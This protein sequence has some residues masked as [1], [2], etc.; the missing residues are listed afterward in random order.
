MP[1]DSRDG[2]SGAARPS[3]RALATIRFACVVAIGIGVLSLLGW[4]AGLPALVHFGA[5]AYPHWPN[6]ALAQSGLAL[7]L[8]FWTAGHRAWGVPPLALAL[9]VGGGTFLQYATSR[10]LGIDRL[11]LNPMLIPT[12][13]IIPGRPGILTTLSL[14]LLATGVL[15][16]L[17]QPRWARAGVLAL[18]CLALGL[19]VTSLSLL[20]ALPKVGEPVV[21]LA[22]SIPS[23]LATAS[24]GLAL[25]LSQPGPRD[26]A[27]PL[28]S[29]W[30]RGSPWTRA[31][32]ALPALVVLPAILFPIEV[33]LAQTGRIRPMEIELLGSVINLAL[34]VGLFA[35]A[36]VVLEQERRTL[37]ESEARLGVATEAYGI[38]VF[39]WHMWTGDLVWSAGAE[40]KLG[41][42]PGA[43]SSYA[44]WRAHLDPAEAEALLA[45][46]EGFIARG[47]LGDRF[48]YQYRF[49]RPDGSLRL[50]ENSA[51]VLCDAQG[52]PAR[53]IGLAVDITDRERQQAQLRSLIQ[54]VPSAMIV[55]DAQGV[56]RRFN[57]AAEILFGL[58]KKVVL[59]RDVA[60]L[61][62]EPGPGESLFG[63]PLVR[64]DL[65]VPSRSL[66]RVV[67]RRA[68][69][70]V[71]VELSVGEAMAAGER[72]FTIFIRDVSE[73]EA[74]L[75]RLETLR[76]EY[77][78]ASRLTTMGEMAAGLA[79]ELN[80]PLAAC[81]NFL[82]SA[83]LM[84]DPQAGSAVQAVR[85]AR[86]QVLRAGAITRKL[87]DFL[88]KG[89]AEMS[90]HP[91]RGVIEDALTLALAGRDRARL[92]IALA[93]APEADSMLA[94]RVQIQ[95][96][97]VNLIRNA[98][99][100]IA[101]CADGRGTLFISTALAE[102]RMIRFTI[103]DTGP[104]I[105]PDILAAPFSPFV[106][107]KKGE[108]MGIG[109]AICRR[110]IE[111]HGGTLVLANRA[112]G[113]A[114]LSFTIPLAYL[115]EAAA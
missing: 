65:L 36:L 64:A 92:T 44:A 71:P 24:L 34:V 8:L 85:Q 2:A 11:L 81:A 26:L 41:L 33:Q 17:S 95:Q 102:Q 112:E 107:T 70:E 68:G 113:G 82:S 103:A 4:V 100:A 105:A 96:V 19:T 90:V 80:Q 30:G 32:L 77:A 37:V 60:L 94:D 75:A 47:A 18:A 31:E 91:V 67:R 1:G 35:W 42:P 27:Q 83:E 57:P 63:R 45:R 54:T 50:I 66:A 93:L 56:I 62:A 9:C 21:R 48:V 53:M 51:R 3:P 72:L 22:S 84:L 23:S 61:L 20:L 76:N 15:L 5:E 69:S 106:S 109:L 99:E 40:R 59:G 12:D 49:R 73:R 110:L 74:A 115:E 79:H 52:R 14:L 16:L 55:I 89:E 101:E 25:V 38:G 86:E 87:R 39:E 7:A 29:L 108:G 98:A 28:Q 10:D 88:A 6:T 13:S 114:C 46:L 97:L 78:H 43:L 104:G 58:S 111:A